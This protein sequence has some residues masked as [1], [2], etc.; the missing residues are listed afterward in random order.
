MRQTEEDPSMPSL[1]EEETEAQG[2]PMTSKQQNQAQNL[3]LL[4]P[5]V[6]LASACTEPPPPAALGLSKSCLI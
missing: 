4:T 2:G 3:C 5:Q 1:T 6:A